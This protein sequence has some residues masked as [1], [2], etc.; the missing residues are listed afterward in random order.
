MA[1]NQLREADVLRTILAYLKVHR[2]F[3]WRNN[4][5]ANRWAREG[6]ARFVRF[7]TVG[8]PDIFIVHHGRCV[9][10]EAK[11]PGKDL[12]AEQ[13]AY[14]TNFEEAGG[15]YALARSIEDVEVV[16]RRAEEANG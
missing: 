3:H 16:L 13:F 11:A 6:K 4:T 2:I 5:G 12:T 8:A 14:A 9:G 1:T 10:I 15:I 7:G